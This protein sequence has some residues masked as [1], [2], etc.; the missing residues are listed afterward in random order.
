MKTRAFLHAAVVLACACAASPSG[1]SANSRDAL[2]APTPA[3][4]ALSGLSRPA[5][6]VSDLHFGLGRLPGG[7]WSPL[8]DFRWSRALAGFLDRISTW[9]GERVDLV[10]A[11][12]LLELWQHPTIRCDTGDADRGCTVEEMEKVADLVIAAHGP[13]FEAL[14]RFAGRGDNRLYIVPGNHDAALLLP[15]VWR[16]VAAA[17]RAKPGRVVRVASG[18]WS[19]EDG[20]VVSEHGHQIGRDVNQYKEWPKITS[21]LRGNQFV[22]RPWGELFVQ[23]LYNEREEAYPVIDNLIPQSNGVRHLMADRGFGGTVG[24]VARFLSFNIFDA[25]LRQIGELGTD[26]S[27]RPTREWNV[28]DSRK[29]G[30]RLFASALPPQDPFRAKLLASD[31]AEWAALRE[32]LNADLSDPQTVPEE[33]VKALCA[34]ASLRA[35]EALRGGSATPGAAVPAA[36]PGAVT[37]PSVLGASLLYGLVPAE[38]AMASH[39]RRRR[40]EFPKM[41]LFVYGHTH[42]VRDRWPVR[43]DEATS[44]TVLNTGAFQRLVDDRTFTARANAAGM[45]PEKAMKEFS[46]DRLPACYAAVFVEWS[47]GAPGAELK[48]WRMEESA[49]EGELVGPCDSLCARL[50]PGCKP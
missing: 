40:V 20:R 10:I 44:V 46:V 9:G 43:L 18:V 30:F 6:F 21:D 13:D 15:R 33:D 28:P 24:D 23:R 34:T 8:E 12:D 39:L 47:E 48:N 14:G 37:C 3:A 4:R 36:E 38:R 5:V 26:A 1:R 42:E 11:G 31:A 25:S 16:N 7:T 50:N 32:K 17:M 22:V 41:T 29:L 35:D 27:G 49:A 2:P 45:S 19:S